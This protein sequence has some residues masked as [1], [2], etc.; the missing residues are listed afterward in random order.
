MS[1]VKV[2]LLHCDSYAVDTLHRTLLRGFDLLG[3]LAR[4][5]DKGERV[6][7]KPNILAGCAPDQAVTTHPAIMEAVIQILRQ[8]AVQVTYGDSSGIT[9]PLPAARDSGLAGVAGRYGVEMGDF[10]HGQQV[11]LAGAPRSRDG[12]RRTTR[13]P[14]ALRALVRHKD[15]EEPATYHHVRDLSPDG[16]FLFTPSPLEMGAE[17]TLEIELPGRPSIAL[18]GEVVRVQIVRDVS[19]PPGLS[20]MAVCFKA[21]DDKDRERITKLVESVRKVLETL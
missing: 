21:V 9:K 11:V 16:V 6:L 18:T 3:G 14:L 1:R 7:L 13:V 5:V 20:G 2:A 15:S 10:E 19:E 4:F 17:L 8:A 12:R